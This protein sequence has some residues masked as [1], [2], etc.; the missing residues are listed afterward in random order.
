MKKEIIS[1]NQ[2][3]SLIVL[4]IL[5]TSSLYGLGIKAKQDFWLAIIL[6]VCGALIM[7]LIYAHLHNTYPEKNL[8]DI[9]HICFGK[10]IGNF[11]ILLF[12]WFS[13][14]EVMT[15]VI[16][17]YQFVITSLDKTP[18][19]I[20]VILIMV[21]C[22]WVIKEGIEILARTATFFIAIFIS[23][24]TLTALLSIPT[25]NFNNFLPIL[26]NGLKPV[27]ESG[28]ITFTYPFGEILV[29]SMVFS[30]FKSKKSVYKVYIA[31][32]LISA[33]LG[34]I[35]SSIIILSIGA[36]SASTTFYPTFIAFRK[37]NISFLQRIE[38]AITIIYV[39]GAFIKISV[40]LLVMCKGISK[41]TESIDYRFIVVPI[42]LI[43]ICVSLFYVES[44]MELWEYTN[45]VWVYHAI[46]YEVILPIIILIFAKVKTRLKTKI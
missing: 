7:V 38:V 20:I 25:M 17:W 24:I 21:L 9:I 39:L 42:S 22:N 3:I 12:L 43:T 33:I 27:F 46:P 16:A 18:A 23:L 4:F 32:L 37:I 26:S 36:S 40:Y 19:I 15:I 6:S 31:G 34:L 8:F 41:I 11:I 10:F 35:I 28:F 5:G 44:T 2:G 1:D 30:N 45:E 13:F 29:F 14:D